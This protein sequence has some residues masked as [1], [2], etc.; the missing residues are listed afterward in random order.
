MADRLSP[1]RGMQ[2]LRDEASD[3]D[4]SLATARDLEADGTPTK[5]DH[6]KRNADIVAEAM[7]R[8]KLILEI[9]GDQRDREV[10]DLKFD[11]ALPDDQ[12]PESLR[13]ARA[14]GIAPDGSV[15]AARPCLVISKVDQPVQQ[16]INEARKA[17]LGIIIKP[18]GNGANKEGA[19]LRQ[20]MIRSIENDSRA[21]I[22][23][24]WALERAVK[25][26]RGAYRILKTQANDGDFDM[27]LVV[28]RIKNQGCVYLDPYAQEPDWSDGEFAFITDDMPV[29]EYKRLYGKSALAAMSAE[30]LQSVTDN[31]PGW[32]TD[33]GKDTGTIR[34]AEY[35]YVE[36]EARELI[37]NP[38][39]G[40]NEL[41]PKGVK[42]SEG[43]LVSRTVQ[44]RQV[45]WAVI[46]AHE[47]LDEEEWEGRYIPIIP[48]I[49]KEYNV[50]GEA[51]WKG[52]VSNAKDAQRLY[53]Y[54]RSSQALRSGLESLAPWVMAEGQDEGYEQM[55]DEANTRAFTRLKYKPTTFEGHLV[56]S[57]KR[58]DLSST[59]ISASVLMAREADMDIQATTGRFNPSLGKQDSNRSGKAI[60]ALKQ[61]GEQS[62]SNYL[63]NLANISMV[64]EGRVLLDLL[65]YVYDRPGRVVRLLGDD[66]KDEREVLLKQPFITGPDGR[67]V[68]AEPNAPGLI[69]A[70]L[71]KMRGKKPLEKAKTYNLDD[72]DY[73]VA[74]TIGQAF[75]TQQDAQKA[76][77]LGVIQAAPNLAP[78][79]IDI[80]A[81][82]EGTDIGKRVKDRLEKINPQLKD[83]E[84]GGPAEIPPEVQAQMAQMQQQMQALQ[85][86][87]AK[88]KSGLPVEELRVASNE[89]IKTLEIASRERIE[90]AKIRANTTTKG[91]E[92]GSK[93]SIATMQDQTKRE[94]QAASMVHADHTKAQDA[95]HEEHASRREEAKEERA[96]R[97]DASHEDHAAVR[98]AALEP[99]YPPVK[100]ESEF[101]APDSSPV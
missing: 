19:E 33:G 81:D 5:K 101:I 100:G 27:D 8:F 80:A 49:G 40:K 24:I 36:Y 59:N 50:D 98:D 29:K 37:L 1:R 52:V 75:A 56:E 87:L 17:R 47:M 39:T 63:E 18:K 54:A 66:P 58:N 62:S 93:E 35:F 12:W 82:L 11:R 30:E 13:K 65:K 6:A 96:A 91:A 86:E 45:K 67:P 70:L 44:K 74:V 14:G 21:N 88:A 32:V 60:Q 61:Q 28:Q 51:A 53:N 41:L 16:V 46:N 2:L 83:E 9:E 3:Y 20:G 79:L 42:P 55:W 92:L 4:A 23:R 73:T 7:D 68:S 94:S 26:G 64:Y 85:Q 77:V 84:E 22:A 99:A 10:E 76:F 78:Y 95:A 71:Q 43:V 69:P 57:P 90:A 31:S 25:C 89:R 38:Q 34:V 15:I 97:R 72:G 48:V